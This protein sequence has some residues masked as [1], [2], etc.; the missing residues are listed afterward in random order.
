M[1]GKDINS[2]ETT[3]LFWISIKIHKKVIVKKFKKS[4][5]KLKNKKTK[6]KF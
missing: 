1:K 6:L 4:L 3:Q 5:E 2:F